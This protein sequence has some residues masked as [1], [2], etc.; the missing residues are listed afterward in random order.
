MSKF[1]KMFGVLVAGLS[2]S[3]FGDIRPETPEAMSGNSALEFFKANNIKTGWNLGNTMDAVDFDANGPTIAEETAWGNPSATQELFNGVRASG[4]DIVRIPVT[5][6]GHIGPAPAYTL[7]TLR[8][9]RV[10]QIICYAKNAGIKAMIINIHHDGNNTQGNN[11]TWGF[12]DFPAAVAD[13]AKN[14]AIKN[15]LSTVWTQ[16]A[17]YF[18]NYGDYLIFETLNEIH[19]GNWG[20]PVDNAAYRK[21]QDI[22]FEWNQAALNAIRATGGNNAARFVAVPGLGSTEPEVVYAAETRKKLLPS[23]GANNF[24]KLIVAVHYYAPPEYTV[25]DATVGQAQGGLI[26]TWGTNEH[27]EHL[28]HEMATLKLFTDAGLAVYLGEWGAPTNVR[29]DSSALVKDTHVNYIRSVAAAAAINGVVP[30]Y[31]D[32]GGDFKILERT[33]GLPK[34]GLWKD[35]L[36][37]INEAVNIEP[38]E[39]FVLDNFEHAT[40]TT[41]NRIGGAWFTYASDGATA[42]TFSRGAGRNGGR[43]GQ[44]VFSNLQTNLGGNVYP[45]VAIATNVSGG[46][47]IPVGMSFAEIE[48]ITFWVKG[49]AGLKFNFTVKTPEN[50]GDAPNYDAY[51]MVGTITTTDVWQRFDVYDYELQQAGWGDPY[52]FLSVN[53]TQFEWSVKAAANTTSPTINAGT[54]MVDDISLIGTYYVETDDDDPIGGGGVCDC[55]GG[56]GGGGGGGRIADS[57]R[58]IKPGNSDEVITVVPVIVTAGEFTAGPNP[59]ERLSAVK[60]FWT[61]REVKSGTLTVFDA[62]GNLVRKVPLCGPDRNVGT[63][64]LTDTKGRQVA[65]GTYLVR[66]VITDVNG[67]KERVSQIIGVR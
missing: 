60:F 46:E 36:A 65:E 67:K 66:G 14:T 51:T 20:M 64:D 19:N 39:N 30:I 56:G 52:L 7:D 13:P 54:F 62:T 24:N 10:A 12:L 57:D 33:N 41:V 1:L 4:F 49:T 21:E 31:W 53:A 38:A 59:V 6:L 50:A 48:G 44:L 34:T 58:V 26:H 22:L 2:I 37:A 5:W 43:A 29:R 3:V 47:T 35:A 40:D 55:D 63:W 45:Q 23:D 32:D 11:N 42:Q 61:G 28:L 8:L 9:Q 27:K 18:K 25:A 17:N 15:Q 16:I